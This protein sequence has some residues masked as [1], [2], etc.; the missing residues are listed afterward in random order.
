MQRIIRE[1][2]EKLYTNI[3][4]NLEDMD[5]ILES[6]N[7]PKL[8]REEI[9]N[10]NRPIKNKETYIVIKNLPNTKVQD[11]IASLVNST[12]HSKKI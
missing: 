11:Q 10:L 2:C 7:L 5:K 3:L 1:Y 9:E 6:F 12:K 8:N 4:D